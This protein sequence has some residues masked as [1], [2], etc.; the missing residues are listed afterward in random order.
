MHLL[1]EVGEAATAAVL[2]A[3]E[4]H[5]VEHETQPEAAE[6]AEAVLAGSTIRWVSQT[7]RAAEAAAALRRCDNA[8][9]AAKSGGG[10]E[11]HRHGI[12]AIA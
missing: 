9:A 4:M 12:H 7:L 3:P 1:Y 8:L 10:D 6:N 5:A 2:D 11:V